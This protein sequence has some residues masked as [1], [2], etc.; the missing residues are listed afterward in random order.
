MLPSQSRPVQSVLPKLLSSH[1]PSSASGSAA[2][3][4]PAGKAALTTTFGPA[5]G[6]LL[7]GDKWLAKRMLELSSDEQPGPPGGEAARSSAG[8]TP[9]PAPAGLQP[10]SPATTGEPMPTSVAEAS[11][12]E[13]QQ[14]TP[15]SVE[16]PGAPP[17]GGEDVRMDEDA[18]VPAPSTAGP[19]APAVLAASGSAAPASAA[20]ANAATD[21]TPADGDDDD[22]DEE[23]EAVP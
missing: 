21:P 17:A 20:G 22:D 4:D 6:G 9:A 11:L 7:A 2:V 3:S 12:A 18:P 5:L 10:N 14:P 19:A 13:G 16:A 1:R 8:A 23:M 15:P